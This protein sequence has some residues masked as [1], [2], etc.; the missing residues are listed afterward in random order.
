MTNGKVADLQQEAKSNCPSK[1]QE[2]S[3][4]ELKERLVIC[5]E[6]CSPSLCGHGAT[7]DSRALR[8]AEE[9]DRHES[10][11]HNIFMECSFMNGVHRFMEMSK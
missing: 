10:W 3:I 6:C 2:H 5:W 11:H 7:D 4:L 9:K 8:G 1:S